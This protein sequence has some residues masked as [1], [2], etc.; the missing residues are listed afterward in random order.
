MTFGFRRSHS[1]HCL[2]LRCVVSWMRNV[3][4][5][6]TCLSAWFPVGSAIW[7]M[8]WNFQTGAVLEEVCHWG[9]ILGIY[10]LAPLLVGLSV[11]CVQLR[12]DIL[13]SCFCLHAFLTLWTPSPLSYNQNEPFLE[14]P[15]VTVYHRN[16]KVTVR[17]CY[18][19]QAG[20]SSNEHSFS[21]SCGAGRSKIKW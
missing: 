9:W 3:S 11:T 5:R 10:S 6:L 8:L 17:G 21:H 1:M 16:R 19:P 13:A 4:H 12:G 7:R 18:M 2:P 20:S 14:L 15:L